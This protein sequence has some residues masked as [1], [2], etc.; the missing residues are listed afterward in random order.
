VLQKTDVV[1]GAQLGMTIGGVAG[2]IGGALIVLFPPEGVTLR[3]V[4]VLAAAL[5]GA[6]FGAWASSMAA[7]A[8]P[9]SRLKPFHADIERGQVLMMVDVP[10]VRRLRADYSCIP[11]A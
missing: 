11:I 2:I 7:C 8:V 4:T 5:V 6:L 3:L 10:M 9:N 1:H